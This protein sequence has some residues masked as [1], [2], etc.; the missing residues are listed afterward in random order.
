MSDGF[1]NRSWPRPNNHFLAFGSSKDFRFYL[2]SLAFVVLFIWVISKSFLFQGLEYTSDLFSFLQMSRISLQR[3]LLFE[4]AWGNMAAIHNFYA[5]LLFS[6]LTYPFGAYGLFL[7]TALLY[8]VALWKL[9]GLKDQLLSVRS[10]FTV[11][12]MTLGPIGFWLFDNPIYGWHLELNFVPLSILLAAFLIEGRLIASILVSVLF[13]FTKEDGPVLACL[14]FLIHEMLIRRQSQESEALYAR[15]KRPAKICAVWIIVFLLGLLLLHLQKT[16]STSEGQVDYSDR[17]AIAAG[18]FVKRV[19]SGEGIY[20]LWSMYVA[21]LLIVL[22][23]FLVLV[24]VNFFK[25]CAIYLITSIPLY[26]VLI[27]PSFAYAGTYHGLLW[28]PRFS[29]LWGLSICNAIFFLAKTPQRRSTFMRQ[30]LYFL[31]M[32]A[33]ILLQIQVLNHYRNYSYAERISQLFNF[34]SPANLIAERLSGDEYRFTECI[35]SRVKT[36]SSILTEGSLF[37]IFHRHDIVFPSRIHNAW[38][39]PVLAVCDLQRR[40]PFGE[41]CVEFLSEKR[42]KPDWQ[43]IQKGYIIAATSEQ[44]IAD[45]LSDCGNQLESFS[46]T[47]GNG[48]N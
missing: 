28:P 4:N 17:L 6:P 14:I 12:V 9:A 31:L 40:M 35:A 10:K 44:P 25:I 2:R 29:L 3:G 32:A 23:A 22:S 21:S 36:P 42:Y 27:I 8:F 37:A 38:S 13:V 39:Y 43:M 5:I 16:Y 33:S 26:I 15:I 7:G 24:Q 48:L 45:V 47:C 20:S 1:M 11:I 18:G 30:S 34:K 41:K 19:S 46:E